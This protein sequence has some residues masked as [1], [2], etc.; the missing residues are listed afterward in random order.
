MKEKTVDVRTR[1]NRTF[2][3]L[4]IRREVRRIIG[5]IAWGGEMWQVV[6]FIPS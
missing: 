6:T 3:P 1:S 5:P 2:H 4:L